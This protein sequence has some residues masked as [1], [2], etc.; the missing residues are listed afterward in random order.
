MKRKSF[1]GIA[2]MAL[3][4]SFTAG[5]T[6]HSVTNEK[7]PTPVHADPE[8]H[9]HDDI[10][11]NQAW[12]SSDSLPTAAG[13]YYLDTD[14][15]VTS[16][17][18]LLGDVSLC[19]NGHKIMWGGVSEGLPTL[20]YINGTNFNLCDCDN[21][22]E[23]KAVWDANE[24][25]LVV[26][27]AAA[28]EDVVTTFKGGYI[29]GH[30]DEVFSVSDSEFNIYG[31]TLI[32][33]G[34]AQDF[35]ADPAVAVSRGTD[36]RMYG[37]NFLGNHGGA[38]RFYSGDAAN[39]TAEFHGGRVSYNKV[40]R[41]TSGGGIS[42]GI[43]DEP[44]ILENIELSY[45]EA[46]NGAAIFC[47]GSMIMKEGTNIHHNSAIYSGG[48]LQLISAAEDGINFSITGGTISN[49][50]AAQSG[51]AIEYT[52]F[53]GFSGPN[54]YSSLN[55]S[56]GVITGNRAHS[57]GGIFAY[58][59]SQH[60][61]AF[62]M[63]GGEIS[64]N[65]AES[66]ERVYHHPEYG[67]I[68]YYD[69]GLGGGVLI[70]SGTE[71]NENV[72][73]LSG[74]EIKN[75][76]AG[77]GGGVYVENN[78]NFEVFGNPAVTGNK[79]INNEADEINLFLREEWH[80]PEYVEPKIEIPSAL[81]ENAHLG[82]K[83]DRPTVFT[84]GLTDGDAYASNFYACDDTYRVFVNDD[85]QLYLDIAHTHNLTYSASGAV[86]TATCDA[87]GCTLPESKATLTLLAPGSLVYDGNPKTASIQAGYNPT[88]F[89]SP[90]ITYYQGA[91]V[92]A[93]C[94]NAGD[95][96]AKVTFGGATA[97]VDF[98]IEKAG[99]DPAP[100]AVPDKN[101]TYG[102]ALSSVTLPDG[103]S[104]NSPE[105]LVGNAGTR[106]HKATFT[107]T[108]AV[109]YKTVEQD[110][111][112]IVAKA[113]PE[114]IVPTGLRS[115][116]NKTLA[117]ITLP[118]GWAWDDDTTSVGDEAG[119]K[120]FKAS[121]T[122]TDTD[123][124]NL[125]EHIDVTV[126]VYEHEHDWTY[127]A[128]GAV[129]TATCG[130]ADC[131]VNSGLTL[132]LKAP[133]SLAYTG[134]AKLASLEAGY[135]DEAFPNPEIKYFRGTQELSECVDC[136]TYQAK[137]TFGNATAV[138]EFTI[139]PVDPAEPDIPSCTATYGQKLSD[140]ANQL[141]SG[142]TWANPNDVVGNV[143]TSPNNHNAIYHAGDNYNEITRA[144][145]V[146]VSKANPEY[147]VPTGLRSLVNK[148]LS[149]ITLPAGWSWD[150]PTTSVG[151]VVGDK[152][153]KGTF[154]PTDTSN[155]NLVEHV[156]ITVNVYEHTH[157]WSYVANGASITASCNGE[158]CPVTTGLTLTLLAPT[159]DMT[160]NGLARVATIKEGYSNIAFP[161]PQIKYYQGNNEV[162][163]CKNVGSYTAKV[164]FGNA[165]A[166]VNFEILS[167]TI[168]DQDNHVSMEVEN[169]VVPENVT[170]RVEVRTDVAQKEV[171]ADYQKIL[172]KLADDEEISKVYDVKLIQTIDGVE[173]EIQ[174]SDLEPG[175]KITVR[176]AIPEGIDMNNVRILHIHSVDDMEFIDNYQIDGN[177]LVFEIDRLSQFVFIS[178]VAAP[179]PDPVTPAPDPV[180][181][182][183]L[184]LWVI[185]LIVIGGSLIG[186]LILFFIF[187]A[188]FYNKWIIEEDE[189]IKAHRL[190]EEEDG[191]IKLVTKKH[192]KVFRKKEEVF[193]SKDEAEEYLE[194]L[195]EQAS[196][197]VEEPKQE[198]EP[199]EEQPV[200]TE[201]E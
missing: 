34:G 167:K 70:S 106:Q 90:E 41:D 154:T 133:T 16:G 156:D 43:L 132:T 160:Y 56:G 152:V 172:N 120:T 171:E 25:F 126:Q 28:E 31:G 79:N 182:G 40:S 159:G 2:V 187:L 150:E 118:T 91:N 165:T 54:R 75:N 200:Q 55:L 59:S 38:I 57:G 109:N 44:L 148:T 47:T 14:V 39:N 52:S 92:V 137:V 37:G 155:Y 112:V 13:N 15:T 186:L 71:Q 107:P 58:T 23:H 51:G 177:D 157:G 103:W 50:T 36:F 20:F 153:F 97:S 73:R 69:Y 162:N 176:M 180:G 12:T 169:A 95:Y 128:T 8:P 93:S 82:I 22:H 11:F 68:H 161:N 66:E 136:G 140:I 125:V 89:P 27:D 124:Y 85:E 33:N 181:P 67:D 98:T 72:F 76:N 9:T 189:P 21:E 158:E 100:D 49:N 164:T 122:P 94:V 77:K 102:D 149:T 115:L 101:A 48:G 60:P 141:P 184:P 96:T 29:A 88:V 3:A 74:G 24:K 142:W 194:K 127:S 78:A 35:A 111:N 61:I 121:F 80:G 134:T 62:N 195:K 183:G 123:N 135:N 114:Y 4:L 166:S 196:Q 201:K 65:T 188:H 63:T 192:K 18:G 45:N 117:D 144:I 147:T 191:E 30:H 81:D 139:T 138:V 198:T 105:D 113:N 143:V 170:I 130:N 104:W 179:T 1:I 17:I 84:K 174:P 199:Q 146:T 64:N 131:T 53:S 87:D 10:T 175:L 178:K 190:G 108:D 145:A 86:I 116:I 42:C 119:N 46:G 7:A 129:I 32:G 185:P 193:D 99:L 173:H 163:E 26:D 6:V 110:V 151:A 83:L 5:V 197:P 19:L 168:V